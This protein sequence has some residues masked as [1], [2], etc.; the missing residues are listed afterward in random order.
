MAV[1][2][3]AAGKERVLLDTAK[4][5][6]VYEGEE[7]DLTGASL[8]FYDFDWMTTEGTL[9]SEGK[10]CRILTITDR[11]SGLKVEAPL[12]HESADRVAVGLAQSDDKK[13]R[14]GLRRLFPAVYAALDE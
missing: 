6:L 8:D 2:L 5:V 13:R 14:K 1:Y 10:A 11:F 9:G 12:E 4:A 7:Y 3:R